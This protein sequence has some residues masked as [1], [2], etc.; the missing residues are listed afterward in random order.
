PT[1]ILFP[2]CYPCAVPFSEQGALGM[3]L[4]AV[5][6]VDQTDSVSG[7]I[8]TTD[9]LANRVVGVRRAAPLVLVVEDDHGVSL[10]LREILEIYGFETMAASDGVAI[11]ELVC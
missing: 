4:G 5:E 2:S 8:S 1:S 7:S 9:R 6:L 11:P 3:A 10:L